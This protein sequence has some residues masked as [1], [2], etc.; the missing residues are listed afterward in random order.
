MQK[1]RHFYLP[2][3][4]LVLL[5]LPNSCFVWR[6]AIRYQTDEIKNTRRAF[7]KFALNT[8]ERE[9][10][11]FSAHFVFL[12]EKSSQTT[13]YKIFISL[14]RSSS[15]FPV[16]PEFF[17]LIGAK[18]YE[19]K[20]ENSYVEKMREIS[21][22]HATHSINDSTEIE[23]VSGY[24]EHTWKQEQFEIALSPAQVEEFLQAPVVKFRFYS[25]A[26]MATIVLKKRWL[27]KVKT[28]WQ[29]PLK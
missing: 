13:D 6:Q 10:D 11:I 4:L 8:Q 3:V 14:R 28:L 5:V 2:F 17:M 19:M 23:V 29:S 9:S 18:K 1:K 7:L 21:E 25:G 20:I 12:K 26:T 15:S 22:D 16:S 24:T 27:E